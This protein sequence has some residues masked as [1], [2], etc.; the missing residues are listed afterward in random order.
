MFIFVNALFL[1]LAGSAGCCESSAQSPARKQY[2]ALLIGQTYKTNDYLA[3][4]PGCLEDTLAVQNMLGLMDLTPY[5]VRRYTDLKASEIR[6]AIIESFCDASDGDVCLF[7]YAG[8]G[9]ASDDS[10]LNGAIVGTDGE[11]IPLGEL[12]SLLDMYPGDKVIILDSCYSGHLVPLVRELEAAN[13]KI[14]HFVLCAAGQF[15]R[16]ENHI[17][18]TNGISFG[19]FT[20]G[21]LHACGFNRAD[22][23]A[24][25]ALMGDRN[26]D[27]AL[28]LSEIYYYAKAYILKY[29]SGQHIQIY[30]KGSDFCLWAREQ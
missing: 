29:T 30:P 9:H 22:G 2:S 26:R 28:T 8:H 19:V 27:G 24:T 13:E 5:R 1:L 10:A 7:Y 14:H 23:P 25:A 3:D 15:E 11:L 20:D 4:L 6:K 12:L 18:Y 16:T 17:S 21:I